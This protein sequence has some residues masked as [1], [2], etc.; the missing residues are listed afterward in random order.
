[1]AEFFD[2]KAAMG[3]KEMKVVEKHWLT[4]EEKRLLKPRAEHYSAMYSH[5]SEATIEELERLNNACQA[6]TETNCWWVDY[7]AAKYLM[8]E[9]SREIAWRN[10][11]DAEAIELAEP[12]AHIM[13][14]LA[15]DGGRAPNAEE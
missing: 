15:D 2:A 7:S 13:D 5:I 1:M 8:V 6:C 14:R 10:R 9:I 4:K 11:R 12:V 3:G